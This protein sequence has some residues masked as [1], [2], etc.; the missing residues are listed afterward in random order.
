[1]NTMV[2]LVPVL[3][4]V[5]LLVMI[6]KAIWVSKQD[7]GEENMNELAGY[8]AQRC[9]NFFL[10][11]EWRVLGIFSVIAAVLLGWSGTLLGSGDWVIA[12]SFFDRCLLFCFRWMDRAEYR[13]KSQCADYACGTHQP[14]QGPVCS[15]TGGTV[16]GLGV[17]GL[18]VLGLSVLFIVFTGMYG[19]DQMGEALEVL[20]IFSGCRIY[21]FARVVDERCLPGYTA[22]VHYYPVL[23]KHIPQDAPPVPATIA[24]NVR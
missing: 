1:M 7:S 11:A 6:V 24:D 23:Y 13:H 12:I 3:G 19:D 2:Y 18:A 17:A 21:V 16:M 20:A 8:I 14:G 5:G 22:D 9:F 10:R 15:F 4:I